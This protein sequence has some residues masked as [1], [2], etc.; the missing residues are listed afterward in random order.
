MPKRHLPA[1][2]AATLSA[3]A[4]A[5]CGSS[6]HPHI[7][8]AARLVRVPG[9][10]AGKIVLSA[11]GA[12][13]IGLATVTVRTVPR[14]KHAGKRTAGGPTVS[15]PG[16]AVIYDPSGRTYAFVSIGRLSFAEVRVVVDHMNGATAYLRS[17]LRPGA[18]VVSR[19]AEE[20]YG[21]Q[22]GVLAQT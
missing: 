8:S 16:S 17:G 3:L 4:L 7:A 12:Q 22:T 18:R 2:L 6:T 9:S 20:L 21:V 11:V 19:G 13:R 14:P 10:A 1:A 15:I 5:A